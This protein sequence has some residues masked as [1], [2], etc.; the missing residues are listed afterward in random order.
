MHVNNKLEL[1]NLIKSPIEIIKVYNFDNKLNKNI[2]NIIYK[3]ET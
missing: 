1:K 2:A 3:V